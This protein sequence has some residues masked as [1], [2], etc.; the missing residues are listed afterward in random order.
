MYDYLEGKVV[1]KKPTHLVLDVGGVGYR[2]SIPISTYNALKDNG[3][4]KIYTYLKVSD[5]EMK[6]FGFATTSERAVFLQLI[7]SVNRLGPAKAI[8]ILSNIK[9][10]ELEKAIEN[11]DVVALTRVKGI[12]GTL[13]RRL[14]TELKGKL[15][16]LSN[17]SASTDATR[18]AINALVSLG[19]QRHESEDMIG[20]AQRELG[21][22]TNLDELVRK[23]LEF[24]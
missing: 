14:I 6:I 8:A 22:D 16:S 9:A 15:P 4:A 1:D 17:V 11:E 10:D 12:G 20:K 23:A 3:A 18:D 21:K 2:V 7:T 24:A 5:D 13:A 19:Y